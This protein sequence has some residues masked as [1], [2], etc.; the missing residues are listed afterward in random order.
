M[1]EQKSAEYIQDHAADQANAQVEA[2]RRQQDTRALRLRRV[3][4]LR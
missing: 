2:E 4:Q 3:A 1:V